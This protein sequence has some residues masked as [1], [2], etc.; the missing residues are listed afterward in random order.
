MAVSFTLAITLALTPALAY[1]DT[2]DVPLPLPL[3]RHCCHQQVEC[4]L[5]EE[6]EKKANRWMTDTFLKEVETRALEFE[7]HMDTALPQ[8]R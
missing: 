6:L 1:T 7:R 3:P 4:S 5:R 8:T 2:I